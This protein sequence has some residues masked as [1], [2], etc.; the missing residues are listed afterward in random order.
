MGYA[1]K[2][3]VSSAQSRIELERILERY[4]AEQ[5]AYMSR[6]GQAVVAFVHLDRQVRF[7]LPLPD[8]ND[9]RFTHTPDR[10]LVRSADAAARE[11]E[12]AVRQRWRALCLVVKAKLEAVDAGITTFDEEFLANLVLPGGASVYES[13]AEDIS[14]AR[15]TGAVPVLQIAAR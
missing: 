3:D 6:P 9:R 10:G 12:Q 4:G 1:E 7:V 5:F 2:T 8:R 11:Y 13:I 15:L 14:V